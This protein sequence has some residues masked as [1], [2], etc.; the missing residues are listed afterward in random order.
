[1][2]VLSKS[3]KIRSLAA[4]KHGRY[5]LAQNYLQKSRARE[6]QFKVMSN[7]DVILYRVLVS[8]IYFFTSLKKWS[9]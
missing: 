1:M 5:G 7:E 4:C 6:Y 9:V 3:T 2:P 8:I